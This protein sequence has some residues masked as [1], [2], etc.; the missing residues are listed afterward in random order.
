MFQKNIIPTENPDLEKK[1][2]HPTTSSW[3]L[4]VQPQHTTEMAFMA[5]SSCIWLY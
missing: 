3:A 1:P 2:S 4:T 5:N